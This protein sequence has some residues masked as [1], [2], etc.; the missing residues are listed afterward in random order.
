MAKVMILCMAGNDLV[1]QIKGGFGHGVHVVVAVLGKAAYGMEIR[2]VLHALEIA[3][4]QRLVLGIDD[5]VV[6]RCPAR[7]RGCTPS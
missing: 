1:R 5:R 4:V 7:R 6:R 3:L 2:E